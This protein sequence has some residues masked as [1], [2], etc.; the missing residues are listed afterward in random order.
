M[1]DIPDSLRV[2]IPITKL[3]PP[4]TQDT[5]RRP[6]LVEHLHQLILTHRL[7]LIS[8]PAGSGKTTLAAD[9]VRFGADLKVGWL[10]LDEGDADPQLSLLGI[11]LAILPEVEDELIQM[12]NQGHMSAHQVA[13]LLINHLHQNAT[14]HFVLILDDFHLLGNPD[15]HQFMDYFIERLPSHAH[16][17]ATTRYDPPLSLPKL[18]ARGE[19]AELRLD[20]LLF[21]RGEVDEFLNHLLNL[22]IP[23]TLLEQLIEKTEGWIAG[24]RLLALSL[25]HIDRDRRVQYINQLAQN[26]RYV[27]E[28]LAQEVLAQQSEDIHRFLLETSILDELTLELCQA[29]TQQS[30]VAEI[31]HELHRNNLFLTSMGDGSYRYHA[32]FQD[33]LRQQAQT[34]IP[35]MLPLLHLRAAAAHKTPGKQIR[36]YLAAQSWDNVVTVI[37]R[38]GKQ[39]IEQSNRKLVQQWLDALPE[40][41]LDSSGWLIYIKGA[42]AYH[43][44]EFA[45]AM[46]AFEAAEAKFRQ[47]GNSEGVFEAIIMHNAS[48]YDQEDLQSQLDY[49]R[50]V[51]PHITTDSQRL[52]IE[53]MMA[54]TYLYEAQRSKAAEH[55]LLT[56]DLVKRTPDKLGFVGFQI[57]APLALAFDKLTY[58]YARLH[59]LIQ[60]FGRDTHV[61]TA[62]SQSI[63]AYIAFWQGDLSQSKT[64]LARSDATWERLGGVNEVHSTIQNYLHLIIALLEGRDKVI[65]RLTFEARDR[66]SGT[67]HMAMRRARWAWLRGDKDET[68]YILD[69]MHSLE[70]TDQSRNAGV[71]RLS[72]EA[73][74][75]LD[76]ADFEKLEPT[77]LHYVQ[78]Q[79]DSRSFYS[80]FV[81]DLRMTL[82]YCY[83]KLGLDEAALETIRAIMNHYAPMSVP[84]RLAQEGGFASPL[85]EYAI[86]HNLHPNFAQSV[87]AMIH[88]VHE[89]QPVKIPETGETLT[90]REAEVLQM[91]IDGASNRDIA[92]ACAISIPTVKTHVSRI[93]QKL[94]V[95]SRTQAVAKAHELRLF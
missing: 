29:V 15:I 16:V 18:R 50:R 95:S 35:D 21:K 45:A 27:F 5:I 17:L 40:A 11:M 83:L 79:R 65:D 2:V 38:Y 66:A 10:S 76:D 52:V 20:S 26:D 67:L 22:N 70:T 61:F 91:L 36:H 3:L 63:L 1:R 53:L 80:L 59:E 13:N 60:Y 46:H 89:P 51:K 64:W 58:L 56:L 41:V 4:D 69:Q 68:R 19:L 84:G 30:A 39:I 73:L 32:L 74:L 62:T 8:A 9:L 23:D 77:I 54:W 75:A 93:L 90:A 28:L 92:Q 85:M 7:I 33:F 43:R 37:N 12:V 25:V 81:H 31:I 71:Y 42:L 94:H 72:I 6:A 55:F 14:H 86:A 48:N 44:G 87:L 78:R 34:A 88:S 57:A 49:L 82:A 24:L 47:E